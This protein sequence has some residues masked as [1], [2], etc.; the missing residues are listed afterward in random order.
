MPKMKRSPSVHDSYARV[1]RYTS[2]H[3][4]FGDMT[5]MQQDRQFVPGGYYLCETF[6]GEPDM[7]GLRLNQHARAQ[8]FAS[9]DVC[10][11]KSGETV[12]LNIE[13][14]TEQS[15]RKGEQYVI[16]G[17]NYR[18]GLVELRNSGGERGWYP[19]TGVVLPQK[20]VA[21]EVA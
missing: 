4:E 3:P 15:F 10:L 11:F 1:L 13:A 9:E 14:G 19:F 2:N 21:Q 12:V 5:Q 18:T 16:S 20:E 8:I 7:V 17:F 6:K